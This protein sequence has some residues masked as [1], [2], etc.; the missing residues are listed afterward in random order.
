MD[1]RDFI[2]SDP[3]AVQDWMIQC[4]FKIES[5]WNRQI[6]NSKK[7]CLKSDTLT[8]FYVTHPNKETISNALCTLQ[9]LLFGLTNSC[10]ALPVQTQPFSPV[11][12]FNPLPGGWHCNGRKALKDTRL[13]HPPFHFLA[14]PQPVVYGRRRRGFDGLAVQVI[15]LLHLRS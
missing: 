6:N 15:I 8:H 4:A 12:P 1:E 13:H 10:T 3:A 14:L 7:T 11:F 2:I 9:R 5:S